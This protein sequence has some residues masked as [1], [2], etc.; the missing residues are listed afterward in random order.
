MSDRKTIAVL[1]GAGFLGSHTA[2]A[3]SDAGYKVRIFDLTPSPWL[4]GD[5][6]MVV[7]DLR[8]GDSLAKAVA[9]CHAV[10]HF[11]GIADIGECARDPMRTAEINLCG[12]I[13][14][15]QACVAAG[16]KRFL[17]ASTVYV[18][19]GHGAFYRASKQAAEGFIQTFWQ[20]YGLEYSILR[21]GTLYG[22][23]AD[24]R[25]RIYNLI[26]E[27]LTTGKILYPGSGKAVREFI[28]VRD[29]ARLSVKVLDA[30]YA[31]RHLVLTG[32]EKL[33]VEELLL[34]IKE[35]MSDRIDVD[36]A[37]EEPPGHYRLT[38]YSF[39]PEVG[40]KMVPSDYVDLGQGL[41]DTMTE[42]VENDP[43]LDRMR[44]DAGPKP[45]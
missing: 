33:S 5:Q 45:S 13:N 14:A 44:I 12:T 8:D 23:R 40:H 17:F 31:N 27:A 11:A 16:V 34:M 2:D 38:P 7:G 19:S 9:G 30:E 39:M 1:G 18:Y 37:N 32:L 15:M 6:D 22:R 10:Y 43:T 28:H 21:Y 25:N 20:E 4:R 3:L 26:R 42:M 24:P 29:A 41:L 35:I 36:W